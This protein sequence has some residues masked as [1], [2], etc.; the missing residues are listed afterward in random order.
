[1]HENQL[2]LLGLLRPDIDRGNIDRARGVLEKL[3]ATPTH[4]LRY[5]SSLGFI[6]DGYNR[7]ER[8]VYAIP[9]I[10]HFF[11]ELH[12]AWPY[13]AWFIDCGA[14]LPFLG[15]LISLLAPGKDVSVRGRS[16]WSMNPESALDLREELLTA[17]DRLGKQKDLPYSAVQEQRVAFLR[18]FDQ[19]VAIDAGGRS[20]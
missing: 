5:R 12:R 9:A 2:I 3:S 18:A 19:C 15:L 1:M 13:W 7:D 16:A 11:S 10:R 8:E 4:V 17:L 6:I 14:R 20:C